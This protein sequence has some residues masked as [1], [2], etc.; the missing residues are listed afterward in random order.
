[1]TK[2]TAPR[3]QRY[4]VNPTF[5]QW[6]YY[7]RERP[8]VIGEVARWMHADVDAEGFVCWPHR[9]RTLDHMLVHLRKVHGK[10]D[11]A[12]LESDFRTAYSE[13]L[14]ASQSGDTR[15]PRRQ[16][17]FPTRPPEERK[18]HRGY[19]LKTATITQIKDLSK[20]FAVSQ[21][22]VLERIVNKEHAR[23]ADIAEMK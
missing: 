11:L 18:Q 19:L 7:Q 6:A 13:Y 4:V 17:G 22:D 15:V 23:I 3:A 2:E 8:G 10:D 14:R 1:L 12:P 16:G 21:G 20:Y 9:T 5:S